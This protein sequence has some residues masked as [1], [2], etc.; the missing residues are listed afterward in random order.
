MSSAIHIKLVPLGVDLHVNVHTPLHDILFQHGVEFPCGGK[1]QCKG[2]R[3]RVMEGTLP[4]SDEERRLLTDEERRAGWRLSCRHTAQTDLTLHVAQWESAILA[5]DSHFTFVPRDGIGIAV[6]IGSTTLVA[7]MIELRTGTVRAVNTALN[8]QARH[9]ADVMSRVGFGVNHAGRRI[10]VDMI[11]RQILTMIEKFLETSPAARDELT[12][13]VLVGNT[14][15]HHLFCDFD[16][17]PLSRYPFS[18]PH[19]DSWEGTPAELGWRIAPHARVRVLPCFGGFVGSDILA[20]V[21]ATRIHQ[22]EKLICLIDLGTNGEI[23]I[24]NQERMRCCSTAA[25]PAFEGARIKM[26]MRAAT[27]AISRVRIQDGQLQAHIVGEG[28]A[29]RGICGSGLVDAVACALDLGLVHSSGRI[30]QP[31]HKLPLI[32][33]VH[34]TQTDIRELQLAKGAIAAGVRILLHELGASVDDVERV[35]LAGAFGN[36]ISV[37][38]ARRI[39]LLNIPADRIHPAGNTAL[40]GAKV[41]LFTDKESIDDLARRISHVGLSSHP[42]FQDIYVEEMTFPTSAVYQQS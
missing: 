2:C 33:P 20:G 19:L 7:Q 16:L 31:P 40:L 25:G 34:L 11:R 8:H 24:G 13:I 38:S 26:G 22:S 1:G 35:H 14:V 36:Y 29:P 30:P 9:G 23:V 5:D 39:G 37:A 42:Q 15:M 21:L 32:D 27:G 28:S 4:M 41:A 3:V 10:L 6:D 18:S 12:D 17:E